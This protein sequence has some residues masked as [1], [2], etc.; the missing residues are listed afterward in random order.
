[1]PANKSNPVRT[2]SVKGA[3]PYMTPEAEAVIASAPEPEA[4]TDTV[5][6][7]DMTFSA[8]VE[9]MADEPASD[10]P[11][12]FY[13]PKV[14]DE[15]FMVAGSPY[16]KRFVRGRFVANSLADEQAARKALAA[17]GRDRADRWQGEDRTVAWNCKKCGFGPCYLDQARYDHEFYSGH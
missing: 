4:I 5:I 15:Q 2:P 17:Y 6:S 13:N 16:R 11:K 7:D 9:F 14:I 1:M 3:N 8:T 10:Y 12:V